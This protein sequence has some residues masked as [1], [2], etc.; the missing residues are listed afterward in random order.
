[1]KSNLFLLSVCLT[2]VC[3]NAFGQRNIKTIISTATDFE[4][5][6]QEADTYFAEK[7]PGIEPAELC[8]GFYRDGDFVKYQR[9][10]A[11]WKKNLN[12][13]GTLGDPTAYHRSNIETSRGSAGP[14]DNIEW[15][16]ISYEDYITWQI[17]MGRTTSIGFHPTDTNTFYV[18]A[19][20]GGVWK[21]TDG[22]ESYSPIGDDLPHLAVS[23][24]I[25]NRDTPSTIYI[26]LSDHVWYGPPS[27]GVYKSIDGGENWESTAF[28]FNLGE[29]VRIY[30][31]IADPNQADRIF[32]GAE[33]GMY[34]TDD[35]FETVE[36]LNTLNTRDIKFKPDDPSIVYQVNSSGAFYKSVDGGLTFA[37]V[38]NVGGGTAQ[39][40][41]TP[42]DP[43][44]LYIR[45][46]NTMKRS[47]DA[48][49]TFGTSISLPENDGQ[50]QF[51]PTDD[52]TLL[53]GNFEVHKSTDNGDSFDQLTHWLGDDNLPMIHVDH[54]NAFI[55]P[56]QDE[57]VYFCCDGGVYRLDV[58]ED[59]FTNLCDGLLIT[60]FY[61]IACSRTDENIIGGG[62]QDNGNVFRSTNGEWQQYA[63]TGDGMN[64]DIDPWN[65][66][67]RYWEYQYGSLQRWQSNANWGI[68]PDG[69]EG[70][71]AWE[72][73]F[74]LDQ[75]LANR[76]IVAYDR[77]YESWANGAFW[78]EISNPLTNGNLEHLAIAPSNSNR[79][80]VAG[81]SSIWVK[82]IFSNDWFPRQMP[83]SNVTDLEV[84]PI[85]LNIVYITESGYS[86]GEKVWKSTDACATWENISG[87]LPNVSTGAI[88]T[89]NIVS[90]GLFVGTDAGVYYTDDSMDDWELYGSIPNTRVSDIELQYSG[91]KIRI[92]THG[93]GVLE[94]PM[95]IGVCSN[96]VDDSDNDGVCN[97]YDACDG[98]DDA[99]LGTPCN[100]GN[101]DTLDDVYIGCD[102]CE[103][104][105]FVGVDSQ[106]TNTLQ[107][108][109][110]PASDWITVNTRNFNL[111]LAE[112]IDLSGRI[113]LKSHLKSNSNRVN[114][115][116]LSPCIYIVKVSDSQGLVIDTKK[117]II[118]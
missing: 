32:V 1:M 104:Q 86:E 45:T 109:P 6:V 62:S 113:V 105:M 16:N 3:T 116:K 22:G 8:Q 69:Q 37:P 12:P 27:I 71:G 108:Y 97:E 102:N 40:A 47:F 43:D 81:G 35:G 5:T 96:G 65:E 10:Q 94:A 87:S 26:A 33:N 118:E 110:N 53:I 117:L 77:V 34:R 99:L 52:E 30:W 39:I 48:G 46:G 38:V 56:L 36:Q 15:D 18:G 68:S 58:E 90:G 85:N 98:F 23:S 11:F 42:L 7:Y 28:S 115:S 106:K 19:A 89:Y 24:I 79:I 93:R 95:S 66:N 31:M 54:R 114:I 14:F 49:E 63:N 64:Q 21:T 9:W 61:D 67:I 111:G 80:Y 82:D 100:D 91:Q 72:T 70:Q 50:I 2:L 73:P 25:I 75:N 20:I 103:G 84:D 76:I 88:E 112:I 55:N 51:S 13:D 78:E 4:K 17:G 74:K 29:Q 59:E 101:S 57:F 92:G 83:T 44:K 107:I 60:Q 41:V